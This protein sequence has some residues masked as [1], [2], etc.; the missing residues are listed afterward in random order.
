MNSKIHKSTASAALPAATSLV[1]L[2][3]GPAA[4]ENKATTSKE[5]TMPSKLKTLPFVIRALVILIALLA[6]VSAGWAQEAAEL[7]FLDQPEQLRPVPGSPVDRLYMAEGVAERLKD[8]NALIIEQPEI[9]FDSDSKYQGIKPDTLKRF[10]DD[11]ADFVKAE[12]EGAYEITDQAGPGVLHVRWAF[13]H[14]RLKFKWSKRPLSYTPIGAAAN[15]IRKARRDDIT[16]KVSLRGV[17]IELEI[18]DSQTSERL[19]AAV[20]SRRKEDEPTSW[21]ELEALM[22]TF[23]QRLKCRLD[24]A[25]VPREQWID[26]ATLTVE[27]E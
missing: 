9:F 25:R 20:E 15:E 6:P 18:L 27:G 3:S 5:T 2:A 23:G 8:Y 14:L 17:V 11:F 13:T 1:T 16:E 21:P 10:A 7:L 26:C 24:N 22:H 19:V 12:L 4:A